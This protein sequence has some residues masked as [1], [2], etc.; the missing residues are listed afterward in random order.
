MTAR[1]EDGA[2]V[3]LDPSLRSAGIAEIRHPATIHP[4]NRPKAVSVGN[5]GKSD[6]TVAQRAARIHAQARNI[7]AETPK[8]ARLVVIEALPPQI[9][10]A[11][12]LHAER[13][14]LW[15]QVVGTLI[16]HG[17]P[18]AEVAPTTLKKWATGNGRADK[19][20]VVAAMQQRWTFT[21]IPDDNAADALALADM[22]AQHL[23]WYGPEA[24]HH[25]NP[26]VRWP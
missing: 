17:I 6:A 1:P 20:A 2:V 10:G 3:G 25:H 4:P 26:N 8:D 22:G 19:H 14:A 15:W 18:V 11:H 7:L 12:G 5:S 13:A 24:E 16:R 23:G 9:P 21:R